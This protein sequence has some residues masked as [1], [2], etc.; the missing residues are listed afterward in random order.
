MPRSP[1]AAAWKWWYAGFRVTS[2]PPCRRGKT[3]PMICSGLRSARN[4]T[5]F[6]VA[7]I[8][9]VL[10][11]GCARPDRSNYEDVRK[12]KTA[13][14]LPPDIAMAFLRE[15]KSREGK[16]LLA[17]ETTIPPCQFT[18]KGVW[19]GGQYRKLVG[20]RAPDYVTDY[21]NGLLFTIDDP[22]GHD[23]TPAERAHPHP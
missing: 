10:A 14:L 16:S 9:L 1:T 15:I 11:A 12:T 18:E 7:L 8:A 23:F 5:L 13:A 17:G 6:A 19:S 22:S 20:R 3:Y 2:S 4:S 21:K